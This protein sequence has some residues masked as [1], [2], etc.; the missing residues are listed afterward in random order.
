MRKM[1]PLFSNVTYISYICIFG[2]GYVLFK[3]IKLNRIGPCLHDVVE[4]VSEAR[5]LRRPVEG[6]A[7]PAPA[8]SVRI[9]APGGVPLYKQAS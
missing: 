1:V 7:V 3:L 5:A 4:L 9:E 6:V 2:S 8:A